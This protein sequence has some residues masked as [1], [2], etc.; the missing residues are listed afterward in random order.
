MEV[1][2]AKHYTKEQIAYARNIDIAE[3]LKRDGEKLKKEGKNHRWVR[4]DSV[5]IHR[6]LWY[7]FS[8]QR[9]GNAVSFVMEFYHLDFLGAMEKLLNGSVSYPQTDPEEPREQEMKPPEFSRNMRRTF[10]YLIKNRKIDADIVQYFVR[11]KKI[12]QSRTHQNAAFI[13]YDEFGVIR[14]VQLRNTSR[15]FCM[16]AA[17]SNAAYHFC[18]CGTSNELF[19]FESPIDLLSFLCLNKDDWEQHTYVSLGGVCIE[20]LLR[21]LSQSHQIEVTH[22]CL[23][24]DAAGEEA[25]MRIGRQL[26]EKNFKWDRLKPFLKDWNDDLKEKRK[27]QKQAE[28][29]I[30]ADG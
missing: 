3:L 9:G 26:N 16:N 27:C 29:G 28:G 21:I 8:R 23:D 18:H 10:A 12:R 4:H 11:Q 19:A 30:D 24:N 13:G 7:Q 20:P 5:T 14:S 6:N 25:T 22:L 1:V 15:K 2:S 17:G